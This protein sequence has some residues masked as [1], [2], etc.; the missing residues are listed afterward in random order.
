M[1]GG[2]LTFGMTWLMC[3]VENLSCNATNR[4]VQYAEGCAVSTWPGSISGATA[5]GDQFVG[6]RDSST[7]KSLL[8]SEAMLITSLSAG[9]VSGLEAKNVET[10]EERFEGRETEFLSS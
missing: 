9:G 2:V 4:P 3:S 6:A 8:F 5:R 1:L 10:V 7:M